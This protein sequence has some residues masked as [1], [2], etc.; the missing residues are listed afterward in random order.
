MIHSKLLLIDGNLV[1]LG[2]A[3]TSIFSM[4]RA[5]EMNVVVKDHP[6][7]IE[8]IKKTIDFRVSQAKKVKS[9]LELNKYNKVIA[10][11]QQLHQLLH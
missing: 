3:N 6:E 5:D 9:T 1:V 10:S 11:L 8:A 4:Q 7:F 2:S